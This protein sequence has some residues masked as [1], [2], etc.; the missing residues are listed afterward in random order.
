MPFTNRRRTRWRKPQ[1]EPNPKPR[2]FPK[3]RFALLIGRA[4]RQMNFE[5]LKSRKL[6]AT[7]IGGAIVTLGEA[8]GISSAVSQNL[9]AIIAAY[10]VG[11][12]IADHGAMGG[13]QK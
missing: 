5:K 4:Y 6:W 2:P 1:I 3:V 12:G 8:V 11:Q 10:V 7:V 9:V 13:T